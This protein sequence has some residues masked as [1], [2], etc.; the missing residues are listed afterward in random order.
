MATAVDRDVFFPRVRAGVFGGRMTQGQV[1]GINNILNTWE[2]I[3]RSNDV[4]W[5]A[6]ILAQS[7]WESASTM[8][9]V[10]EAFYLGEPEPAE[11]YRRRLRYYPFYGRGLVQITW[12]DNYRK[13][14]PVVG[15]DLVRYPDQA[16]EPHKSAVILIVGMEN[17]SFTGTG[18][19]DFFSDSRDDPLH[20]RRIVNGMDHA[21]EIEQ[22]HLGFLEA[23]KA[24]W[25]GIAP[26]AP[27]PR[28]FVQPSP[29][30][31][32][33]STIVAGETLT[34]RQKSSMPGEG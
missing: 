2:A 21:Y 18:L 6:N 8:Q 23:L 16:L 31:T 25:P 26:P 7:K 15:V 30:D 34:D 19:G 27:Q 9:P 5:L 14:S 4:R 17:G 11:S 13:F 10:R 12:E 24:G 33:N 28:E 29:E 20:A 22:L 3:S 32:R 1:D